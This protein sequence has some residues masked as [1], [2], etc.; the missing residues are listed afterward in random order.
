MILVLHVVACANVFIF[1]Y[2]CDWPGK[3]F[4]VMKNDNFLNIFISFG[5]FFQVFGQV[6]EWPISKLHEVIRALH[7][8]AC[9]VVFVLFDDPDWQRRALHIIKN[10]HF[11]VF[12]DVCVFSLKFLGSLRSG[13]CW[14]CTKQ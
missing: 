9:P 14:N 1:F 2:G 3:M 12:L 10:D 7:V 6:N 5:L 11:L 13:L 8:T 4:K